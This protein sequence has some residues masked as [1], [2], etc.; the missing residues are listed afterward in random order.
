LENAGLEFRINDFISNPQANQALMP[1]EI[2]KY[3]EK[4]KYRFIGKQEFKTAA[5]H[6][7]RS[8][9]KNLQKPQKSKK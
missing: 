7:Q 1:Y 8:Q 4:S 2:M 5:K 3:F 9:I 6:F